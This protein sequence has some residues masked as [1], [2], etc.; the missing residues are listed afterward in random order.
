MKKFSTQFSRLLILFSLLAIICHLHGGN[1]SESSFYKHVGD[2]IPEFGG[3]TGD[4]R[5]NLK[6]LNQKDYRRFA[7]FEKLML[8]LEKI[9]EQSSN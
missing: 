3:R 9:N 4:S 7:D 2:Y 6:F 8:A 1:N 5:V